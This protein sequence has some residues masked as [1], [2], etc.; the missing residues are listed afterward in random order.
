VIG[1]SGGGDVVVVVVDYWDI[2]PPEDV[3]LKI[4]R[5]VDEEGSGNVARVGS[6]AE[7]PFG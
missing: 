2:L 3:A 7:D 1:T 6:Q 4:P 5:A